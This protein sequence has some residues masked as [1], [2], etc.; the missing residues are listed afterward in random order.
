MREA[1]WQDETA[2]LYVNDARDLLTDMATGSVDCIVAFPPP[3]T[4]QSDGRDETSPARYIASLR[5]VLGQ[6]HRVLADTG[7]CWMAASDCYLG[8]ELAAGRIVRG[9]R[10][11]IRNLI[12]SQPAVSLAGLPWQLAAAMHDDG[13]SIV[14]AIVWFHGGRG[15]KPEVGRFRLSYDTIFVLVKQA[16]YHFDVGGIEAALGCCSGE[17]AA[18]RPCSAVTREMHDQGGSGENGRQRL[19]FGNPDA[20]AGRQDESRGK[21]FEDV[22]E[23]PG[24]QERQ[25]PVAVPLRCIAVGCRPGGTV[26]EVF[27]RSAATAIAARQLERHFVGIAESAA[28][29]RAVVDRLGQCR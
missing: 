5:G 17:G 8:E 15:E 9:H 12:T 4:P 18:S 21:I 10:R 16:G 25:L 2:A 27:T 1:Y 20:S 26:L 29:C 11:T 13:W 19:L 22:W 28:V 14:N 24:R 6:A 23:L 3:W 7:T